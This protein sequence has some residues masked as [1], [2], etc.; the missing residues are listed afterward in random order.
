MLLTVL[1][2][3]TVTFAVDNRGATDS[4]LNEL[5]DRAAVILSNSATLASNLLTSPNNGSS[6]VTLRSRRSFMVS[7]KLIRVFCG[8]QIASDKLGDF[9]RKAR[10]RRQIVL[11][12]DHAACLT[13][14]GFLGVS[15]IGFDDGS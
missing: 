9:W 15:V 3:I 1:P 7:R 11:L 12:V 5:D 8:I 14:L 13:C 4:D 6:K 2:S 10:R